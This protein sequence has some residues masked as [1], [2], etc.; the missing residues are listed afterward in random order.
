MRYG[1]LSNFGS[2]LFSYIVVD[3]LENKQFLNNCSRLCYHKFW[4]NIWL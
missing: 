1:Q 2:Y 3:R 4:R